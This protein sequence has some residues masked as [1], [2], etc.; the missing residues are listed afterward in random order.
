MLEDRLCIQ[1]NGYTNVRLSPEDMIT[2]DY[3]N[4]GCNGGLLSATVAYM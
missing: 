1:S 3:S 4:G 2:C